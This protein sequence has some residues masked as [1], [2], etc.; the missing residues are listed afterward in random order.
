MY[1]PLYPDVCG[2]G[3]GVCGYVHVGMCMLSTDGQGGQNRA[4]TTVIGGCEPP[5][6]GT[7]N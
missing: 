4:L 7:A 3:P 5:D 2:E 1:G 6:M